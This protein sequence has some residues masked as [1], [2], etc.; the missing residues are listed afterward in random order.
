MMRQ[1]FGLDRHGNAELERSNRLA[2]PSLRAPRLCYLIGVRM[3]DDQ[4]VV[5]LRIDDTEVGDQ[6]HVLAKIE[7]PTGGGLAR[8]VLAGLEA[9]LPGA[10][11]V[12]ASLGFLERDDRDFGLLHI[13][14]AT[15]VRY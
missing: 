9:R 12:D 2:P 8:R 6:D 3:F 4:G 15:P 11:V 1:Q 14:L 5:S 13:N 7:D 10:E